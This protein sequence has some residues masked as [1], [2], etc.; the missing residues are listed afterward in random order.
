MIFQ[1]FAIAVVFAWISY[2][3][4]G[5][6]VFRLRRRDMGMWQ[7]LGKPSVMERDYFFSKFPFRGWLLV[8]RAAGAIDR[9]VLLLF[10]L[11]VIGFV[12]SSVIAL[13]LQLERGLE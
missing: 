2:I 13:A 5:V 4:R 11:C 9:A 6:A 8:Y 7:A 3:A 10:A 1:A 12:F